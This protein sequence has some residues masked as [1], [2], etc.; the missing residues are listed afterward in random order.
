MLKGAR[1]GLI[2]LILGGVGAG[3]FYGGQRY[4]QNAY[5]LPPAY[6]ANSTTPN[7]TA[8]DFSLFWKAW[9]VINDKYYGSKNDSKQVDGAI[10]GMVASLGDPYTVYLPPSDNSL[11]QSDLQGNFGGIGA[12]L[13]AKDGQLT[14]MSALSGTPAEKAGLKGGDVISEVD[15]VKTAGM[16]EDDAINKIRGTVGTS[17]VL[18]IVRP[19]VDQPFK[20]TLTRQTITVKSVTASSIGEGNSIAY[21]KV[22]E[23]G[24]DTADAFEAALKDAKASNKQGLVIDLRDDPGGYLDQAVRM[25]GMMI[26]S[27]VNSDKQVLKDRTAV[28]ERSKDGSETPDKSAE[29]PIWDTQKTVVLMNSGSASAA[30]IFSGAM[31]DY[32]RAKLVGT[33]SFGKGSVQQLQDLGNGGSIKVTIAK[34]FTPLGVGIDGKGLNPDVEVDLPDGTVPSTSDVQVAKALELLK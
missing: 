32:G 3:G 6:L 31:R 15:G 18:T 10:S 27:S 24:Q 1:A 14:V 16:N 17:V 8:G 9:N 19:G 30:E 7:G 26:P 4:E 22:N 28:L 33:K 23:F 13:T 11:F 5:G 25:I 21:I 29:A 20:V 2:V 34:W 12:E